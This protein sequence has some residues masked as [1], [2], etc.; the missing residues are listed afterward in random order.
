MTSGS[1]A[2]AVAVTTAAFAAGGRRPFLR[3]VGAV[4]TQSLTNRYCPMAQAGG[5]SQDVGAEQG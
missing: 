3:S 2:L 5:K 4:S 1:G